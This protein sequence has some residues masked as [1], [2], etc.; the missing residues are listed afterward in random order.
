M[1]IL[2]TGVHKG[3]RS[4]PT[5]V[6]KSKKGKGLSRHLSMVSYLRVN[7]NVC[8]F[9]RFLAQGVGNN[10][11][12]HRDGNLRF[13]SGKLYPHPQLLLFLAI[14]VRLRISTLRVV[15]LFI[16]LGMDY[17]RFPYLKP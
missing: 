2:R 14:R 13:P 12:H 17:K 3:S 15:G 5:T 7:V 11:N 8:S 6:E 10:C 4:H 1:I 9:N 16:A